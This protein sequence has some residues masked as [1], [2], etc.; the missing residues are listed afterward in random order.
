MDNL[1]NLEDETDII[2]SEDTK[3]EIIVR[4]ILDKVFKDGIG[5]FKAN[6]SWY[7]RE[8]YEN[9]LNKSSKEDLIAYSNL[10]I[11]KLDDPYIQWNFNFLIHNIED[12]A[13]EI[14]NKNPLYYDA[15]FNE[16]YIWD[17][18]ELIWIKTKESII[19]DK[20]K[21]VFNAQGLS[22][23]KNRTSLLNAL[24][25]E[26]QSRKPKE[27]KDT[28]LQIGNRIYDIASDNEYIPIHNYFIKTKIPFNIGDTDNTPFIDSLF[29]DWQGDD[30]SFLY[31]IAA[32]TISPKNFMD[33]F[34]FFQ[35]G[36]SDGKSVYTKILQTL[37]GIKNTKSV[38][39][40][41]VSDPKE[42]FETS[43]LIDK[44]LCLLGDGNFPVL[45][46]TKFLKEACGSTDLISAQKKGS[47][48]TID[49]ESKATIIGSFNTLPQT[50]DLTDGFFRR[51]HLT[52]WNNK[53][54]GKK[55]VF[56]ELINNHPEEFSNLLNK[57]IVRLRE[58]YQKREIDGKLSIVETRNLYLEN[59]DIIKQ[60]IKSECEEDINGVFTAG[61]AYE[62][63]KI[64]AERKRYNAFDFKSFKDSLGEQTCISYQRTWVYIVSDG[65]VYRNE[66]DIPDKYRLEKFDHTQ[67]TLYRGMKLNSSISPASDLIINNTDEEFI[68]DDRLIVK[69]SM[70][71][72]VEN[73]SGE[74]KR[75]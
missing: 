48:E 32:L 12:N 57:L 11:K 58:I 42:R 24:K 45:K 17:K 5:V 20:V 23:H 36:G 65:N 56:V 51:M 54:D 1:I 60:F 35:G 75:L 63:F 31:D 52:F 47:S 16:W 7:N 18:I 34:F 46:N 68:V 62:E 27:P 49:F 10:K 40:E 21:K 2:Y 41:S 71:D 22:I 30:K 67:L 43:F 4:A 38:N 28:W 9:E 8:E 59:S 25:D 39:I 66:E 50:N 69:K 72:I 70:G 15:F 61:R 29:T 26:T 14:L 55:D 44:Y 13:K 73:K 64:W 37:I 6:G 53:F 3:K 19:F 74:Y 33:I